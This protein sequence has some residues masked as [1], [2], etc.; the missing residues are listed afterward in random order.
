[1]A[2]DSQ[3][4]QAYVEEYHSDQ[5]DAVNFKGRKSPSSPA[6]AN[7]STKRSHPSDLDKEKPPAQQQQQQQQ[8][9]QQHHQQDKVHANVDQR[10][11]SGYS[12]ITHATVGSADSAP[13]ATSQQPRSPP[14]APAAPSTTNTTTATT[15]AASAT[16]APSHSTFSA[17]APPAPAPAPTPPAPKTRRPTISQR[18]DSSRPES[19]SRRDSHASRPPPQRRPT[20][21]TS[22]EKRDRRNSRV[23]DAVC[24]DPNCTGC[25][26]TAPSQLQRRRPDLQQPSQ[27]ARDVSRLNSTSDQRSMRSDPSTYYSS[28]PSPTF[29]RPPAQYSQGAA[30]IQPAMTRPRASSRAA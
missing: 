23:A 24:T 29:T 13:S 28:P 6:V 25:G 11:D 21:T 22:Q 1:M 4:Y 5:S 2:T 26:P 14:V 10:S 19:L 7:V 30:V 16:A 12:S 27:S 15:A 9:H 17:P 8:Q 20:I 3:D 18:I